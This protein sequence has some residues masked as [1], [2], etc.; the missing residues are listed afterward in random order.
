MLRGSRELARHRR[1]CPGRRSGRWGAGQGD[2]LQSDSVVEKI[3]SNISITMLETR[4]DRFD[5][6][7][8]PFVEADSI[9]A[10][11]GEI[12]RGLSVSLP[13]GALARV[14]AVD[15]IDIQDVSETEGGSRIL[16]SWYAYASGGHWG[17]QHRRVIEYRALLDVDEKQGVWK[18]TDLTVLK[19]RTLTA[20]SATGAD[21]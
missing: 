11:G 9:G 16:A 12:R 20:P 10:V 7:M 2:A 14:E 19:A 4:S 15:E 21:P 8:M 17:H 6:A 18:L 1:S 13:S 5:A 3:L